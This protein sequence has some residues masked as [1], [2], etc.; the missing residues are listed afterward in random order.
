MGMD[1]GLPD[2]RGNQ[3]FW[4]AYPA[5]E[6]EGLTFIDHKASK[7]MLSE[8]G[9]STAIGISFINN[10]CPTTALGY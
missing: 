5:L 3:S 2:F 8:L 6:Q 1:S 7:Q 10:Q 9:A 4:N